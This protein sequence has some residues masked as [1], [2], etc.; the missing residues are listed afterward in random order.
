M[1]LGYAVPWAWTAFTGNTLW[2][3]LHLLLLPLLLPTVVVPA[4]MPMAKASGSP[5]EAGQ[6]ATGGA[7]GA[8]AGSTPAKLEP[9]PL[10]A[11]LG[12]EG[13]QE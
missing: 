8:T 4:L 11:E 1:V 13:D 2:D 9:Q 10:L 7:E 5:V 6:S 12:I 3:W